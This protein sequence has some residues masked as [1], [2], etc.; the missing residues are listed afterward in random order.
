M[1]ILGSTSFAGRKRMGYPHP[2]PRRRRGIFMPILRACLPNNASIFL[3]FVTSRAH[4]VHTARYIYACTPDPEHFML[5]L[6][7]MQQRRNSKFVTVFRQNKNMRGNM[8]VLK[9]NS[10][11]MEQLNC[12]LWNVQKILTKCILE[13]IKYYYVWNIC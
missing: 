3:A 2:G 9:I 7:E 1:Q 11:S 6:R 4:L 5:I 10:G 12:I 8:N 13:T